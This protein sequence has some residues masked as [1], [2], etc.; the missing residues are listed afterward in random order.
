MALTH[1]SDFEHE[2]ELRCAYL[3]MFSGVGQFRERIQKI[4]DTFMGQRFE[5]PNL[6]TL[7]SVLLENEEE[8]AKSKDIYHMSY[9]MLQGYLYDMNAATNNGQE[10]SDVSTLE[11][12]KWFV[13]K[14]KAIYNAINMMSARQSTYIGFIWAPV[15]QEAVIKEHLKN[16]ATTEFNKW[17]TKADSGLE[18]PTYFPKNDMID[19]HQM[20]SDMYNV[21]TYEEMN[22]AVFSIVTFP[23]LFSVMYGDWGHGM[24]FFMLGI[25]LVFAEPSLRNNIAL[26]GILSARY[27]ILMIG[28]FSCYN[29]LIY[30]EFFSIS[31]DFFGTCYRS[32]IGQPAPYDRLDYKGSSDCVYPFGLDP[33]WALAPSQKLTF[34]NTA[35]EKMSVIIAFFQLNFGIFCK[36]L[37]SIYFRK[38][39]VLLFD[40]FTGFLIFFG[41]I[42]IMIILIYVKWWYPVDAYTPGQ[43]CDLAETT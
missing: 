3:V 35:K 37:N 24:V 7:D 20:L 6:Q 30:N 4:C 12:Y 33:A 10:E 27:F 17:V 39:K 31:N 19:V 9:N 23:F 38:W 41:F 43:T 21:P 22:P 32:D 28:F 26:K 5:I 42:G 14:E 2:G 16:F 34:T 8:I 18:P 36:L 29:G 40:V 15:D 1:F 11:I 25:F 13:A